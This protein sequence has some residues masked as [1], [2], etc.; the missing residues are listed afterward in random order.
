MMASQTLLFQMLVLPYTVIQNTKYCAVHHI[1]KGLILMKFRDGFQGAKKP[2]MR[3]LS[4]IYVV[5]IC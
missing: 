2:L 4:V 3:Y 5:V 1:D